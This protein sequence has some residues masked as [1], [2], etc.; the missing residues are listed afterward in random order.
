MPSPSDDIIDS[1][2]IIEEIDD[3]ESEL[4]GLRDDLQDL[5]DERDDL[6]A[7]QVELE[8]DEEANEKRLTE[9]DCE[10]ESIDLDI[11]T[12]ESDISALEGEL[13]PLL[14]LQDEAEPYCPDWR[15]G[16]TLIADSYFEEYAYELAKDIG[17]VNEDM[18]W[19]CDCIDWTKA[20]DGLKM[21]YT[22]VDFDGETYW[23]R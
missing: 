22:S 19:P 21:D 16:A 6:D 5:E 10:I 2:E 15:H 9:I 1:R 23:V 12:K 11:S 20:A 17:A 3:L 8:Q 4:S 14:D 13:Q 7:E 18:S